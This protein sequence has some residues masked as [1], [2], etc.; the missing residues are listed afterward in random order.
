MKNIITI[1]LFSFCSLFALEIETGRDYLINCKDAYN[2]SYNNNSSECFHFLNATINTLFTLENRYK[3]IVVPD[4]NKP[5]FTELHLVVINFL[6]KNP[7]DLNY[8]ATGLI[9][10]ALIDSYGIKQK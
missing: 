7:K 1:L 10:D 9:I 5:N 3:N 8:Y 4:L 6:E 2:K